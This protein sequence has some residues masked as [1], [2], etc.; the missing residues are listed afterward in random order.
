MV[1][2]LNFAPDTK[3]KIAYTSLIRLQMQLYAPIPKAHL[4]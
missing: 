2:S 3:D 4:T 1:L